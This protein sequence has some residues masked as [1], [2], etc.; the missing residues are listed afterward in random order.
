MFAAA[1]VRNPVCNLALM[2]GTSD[3]PDWCFIETYGSEGISRFTEAPSSENLSVFYS[4]SPISH[5]SKVSLYMY[6]QSV[7]VVE[8]W[9]EI[10]IRGK[11]FGIVIN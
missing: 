9:D 6:A 3:I 2:V 4:K 10:R 1:A 7:F 8:H 5:L 11:H